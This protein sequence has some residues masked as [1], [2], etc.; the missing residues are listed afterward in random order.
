[1]A[2]LTAILLI[3]TMLPN[4]ILIPTATVQA[5]E[6]TTW[7]VIN[8]S[9]M[10]DADLSAE[11]LA[12]IHEDNWL[13]NDIANER[14]KTLATLT[15]DDFLSYVI[16]RKS[17]SNINSIPDSIKFMTN[18][19]ELE[20]SG[21]GLTSLPE[22]IGNLTK[23]WQLDCSYNQL[24]S[25]PKSIWNITNLAVL[26][27]RD[28]QLT[29]LP[30]SIGNLTNL[31]SLDCSQ[32][33]LRN[34]P[35][36]IGNLTN[37]TY[38]D[39]TLTNIT[40]LP[41]SIGNLTKPTSLN[42]ANNGLTSLPESIGNL[43][44]LTSL[45]FSNNRLT[46][47]PESI[48]N[49]ANLNRLFFSKNNL[50]SL[51][52]SIGNLTKLTSLNFSNNRLTSLPESIG[53]T[54]NLWTLDCSYNQ[55]TSLPDS[56]GNLTKLSN[57][58]ASC[59]FL[60][61]I[62]SNLISKTYTYNFIDTSTAKNQLSLINSTAINVNKQ[63]KLNLSNAIT[64][65]Y[66]TMTMSQAVVNQLQVVAD[67]P[68]I[69]D[70]TGTALKAGTTNIRLQL[71]NNPDGNIHG[72]TQTSIKVTVLSTALSDGGDVTVTFTQPDTLELIVMS[73]S[74]DF[75]EVTGLS[76]D[77]VLGV[78][79][80]VKSSLP[81]DLNIRATDDFHNRVIPTA[82]VIKTNKL[83]ISFDAGGLSKLGSKNVFTNLVT[84]APDTSA[85]VDVF[86]MHTLGFDLS[87]TVG[88]KAGDYELPLEIVAIQK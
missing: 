9:T 8:Y 51:P 70:S 84:N 29:S 46:S 71:P 30:E 57:F 74:F 55:L 38:L 28:N 18:L 16:L 22:S 31:I 12:L 85:Q 15:L 75:G 25:L 64:K 65:T 58:D 78:D 21:N 69:I 42:C 83:G 19:Q 60:T 76:T 61:S 2:S 7:T 20:F 88:Y 66:G 47:L 54:T 44:K 36:S 49:L 33:S 32:N 41:D 26:T 24:T 5:A 53:N 37:L 13:N 6:D 79:V 3:T 56:I 23:L 72:I 39:C 68:T 34:L 43:T 27:C 77:E 59:N 35:D 52:D 86:K 1:M 81:Y 63:E 11:D 48:G 62:P 10:T 82:S 45:N 73:N 67:D 40:S 87:E 4:S 17:W 50:T 14:G 80:R